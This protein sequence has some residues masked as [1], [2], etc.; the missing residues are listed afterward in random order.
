MRFWLSKI[1]FLGVI[2]AC[3]IVAFG[4]LGRLHPAFDTFAHFRLHISTGLIALSAILL[5]W[6]KWVIVLLSLTF[7]LV[8]T[9][10][11]LVGT[12]FSKQDQTAK[13]DKQVYRLFHLNLFWLNEQK[14][15]VIDRI[16]EID[17]F[18][19]SLSETSSYWEKELSRLKARWPY[20]AH[21]PEFGI[22]GG[23]Q[24]YS[25]V[26][27]DHS[28]DFCGDFG[29]FMK[30]KIVLPNDLHLVVGS[31]HPRWP[32]PASGPRQYRSFI[33]ILQNLGPDALIAGDFNATPWS[34]AVKGFADAGNLKIIP[35]IGATWFLGTSPAPVIKTVGLPI[36]HILVKGRVKILSAETL[37]EIGSDHLPI[38]VEFQIQ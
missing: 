32:W 35:G 12:T 18:L 31:V 8:G 16:F 17:P 9:N 20:L 14:P 26:P 4:F 34:H 37:K 3:V 28:D 11:S 38:L 1:V 36:D 27:F 25:K 19:I 23:V 29:S 24:L 15:Q 7:G 22:R 30:T 10:S 5:L 21:C 13:E 6:R 2:T 33:P